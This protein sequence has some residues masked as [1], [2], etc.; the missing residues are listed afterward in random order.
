[1]YHFPFLF[2]RPTSNKNKKYV[3]T[4]DILAPIKKILDRVSLGFSG[5]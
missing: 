5:I 3:F 1:M 2:P 4:E